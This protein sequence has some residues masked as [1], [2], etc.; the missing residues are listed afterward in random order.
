MITNSKANRETQT[1][2]QR[3]TEREKPKKERDRQRPA[4]SDR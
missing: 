1:Y 2:R 4:E 3:L